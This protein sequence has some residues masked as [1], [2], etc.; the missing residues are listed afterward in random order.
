VVGTPVSSGTATPTPRSD[1]ASGSSTPRLSLLA[2]SKRETA[3]RGLYSMFFRGPTLG[4]GDVQ[5]EVV[6]TATSPPSRAPPSDGPHKSRKK[7]RKIES[8]EGL[9][10]EDPDKEERKRRKEFRREAERAA[11]KLKR[12]KKK[13]KTK[14]GDGE[15]AAKARFVDEAIMLSASQE[16]GS[17]PLVSMTAY[18]TPQGKRKKKNRRIKV[19]SI[20]KELDSQA[21]VSVDDRDFRGG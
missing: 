7:K 4:P 9:P 21:P 13:N 14:D 15:D 3:R 17:G 20:E 2:L 10:T 11:M 1:D 8:C 6:K 19:V 5:S 18:E 16:E 12:H